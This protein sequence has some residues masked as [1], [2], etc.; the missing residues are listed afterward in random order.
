MSGQPT[1]LVTLFKRVHLLNYASGIHKVF[2]EV[3]IKSTKTDYS[4]TELFLGE[5]GLAWQAARATW[6]VSKWVCKFWPAPGKGR[7]RLC[8]PLMFFADIKQTNR[9]IF[10]SI[11]V[12]D[13]KY[14]AHLL[15]KEIENRS[16]TYYSCVS[17]TM[18]L[19][20]SCDFVTNHQIIQEITKFLGFCKKSPDFF[21]RKQQVLG[22]L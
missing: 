19:S 13:R 17:I 22:I 11:S 1:G 15:K 21:S 2:I 10:T 12:P 5:G 8:R 6:S 20:D 3:K 9:L 4:L 16:I 7:G 14:T 18:W